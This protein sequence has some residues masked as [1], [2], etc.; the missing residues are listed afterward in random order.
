[1]FINKTA[2]LR[3]TCPNVALGPGAFIH[4]GQRAAI[5]GYLAIAERDGCRAEALDILRQ[6]L[7]INLEWHTLTQRKWQNNVSRRPQRGKH[8]DSWA[9]RE[10]HVAGKN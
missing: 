8:H 10:K 4:P 6:A 3:W 5:I 1:M 2:E 7:R 9:I